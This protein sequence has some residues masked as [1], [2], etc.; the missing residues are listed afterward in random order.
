M[1]KI[2]TPIGQGRS[3]SKE[4]I[5]NNST[6]TPSHTSATVGAISG[7]TSPIVQTVYGL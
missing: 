3:I 7:K 6:L 5:G 4:I 1:I 2:M